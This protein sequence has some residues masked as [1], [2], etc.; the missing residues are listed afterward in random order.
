MVLTDVVSERFDAGVRLGG[1]M[2]KDMIAIRIGPDIPMKLLLAHRI[3]FSSKCSNVVSSPQIIR[4]LI[5]IFH[6]GYSKSL[7]I[8]TGGRSSCSHGRSALLN[9]IDLII[10]AAIDGHG[11]AYLPMIRLSGLL[12]KKTDTCSWINSHQIYPVITCTIHTVD[13]LARYS[14][15]L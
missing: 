1:E 14:H 13:M 6:I 12:K 5:C 7:E 9:T 11:L 15:Y 4:Q 3:I 10:D 8:N 2:D